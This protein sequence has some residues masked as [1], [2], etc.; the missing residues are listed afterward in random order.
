[1]PCILLKLYMCWYYLLIEVV[2][3]FSKLVALLTL[4]QPLYIFLFQSEECLINFKIWEKGGFF[5]FK[6]NYI[7]SSFYIF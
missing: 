4:G 7:S 1:M 2:D 6:I 3:G 5:F